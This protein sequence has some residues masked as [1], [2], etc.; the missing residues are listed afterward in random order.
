MILTFMFYNFLS[1]LLTKKLEK[2]MAYLTLEE[3]LTIPFKI[4]L[5]NCASTVEYFVFPELVVRYISKI[6]GINYKET[7]KKVYGDI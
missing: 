2:T 4:S 5:G 3:K 1:Y 7:L 6:L